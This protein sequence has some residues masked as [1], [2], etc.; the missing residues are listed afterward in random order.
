M[1]HDIVQEN[2]NEIK[3]VKGNINQ[4]SNMRPGEEAGINKRDPDSILYQN[5]NRGDT[6]PGR[7]HTSKWAPESKYLLL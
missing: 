4:D 3:A 6:R 2:T 1:S 5:I 7:N